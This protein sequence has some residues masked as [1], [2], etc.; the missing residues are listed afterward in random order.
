LG[1]VEVTGVGGAALEEAAASC[2]RWVVHQRAAYA[3][4]LVRVRV[5]ARVRGR[6]SGRVRVG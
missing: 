5:G 4:T 1:L 3:G 2:W 6:G